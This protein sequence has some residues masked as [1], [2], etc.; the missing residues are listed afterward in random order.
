MNRKVIPIFF[1]C[2]DNFVKFTIVSLCSIKQNASRDY[3]YVVYVLHTGITETMQNKLYGLQDDNFTVIFRDVTDYLYSIAD[4][5]PIRDYYSKTTYY[6]VFIAE[7]YPEYDKAIYID[8]DTVVQG[9]I[10]ELY[11][12]DIGDCY[13]GACHEQAMVQVDEFGTYVERVIGICS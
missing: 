9:D 4:K 3:D 6:R 7:M 5:L 10:S 11:E 13:V 8:S 1:A 12:T 2:D